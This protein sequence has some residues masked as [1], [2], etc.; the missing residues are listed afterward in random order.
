VVEKMA[1]P[2]FLIAERFLAVPEPTLYHARGFFYHALG[3]NVHFRGDGRT[4][5]G[6]A[7]EWMTV[8]RRLEHLP[9]CAVVDLEVTEGDLDA[10][11]VAVEARGEA[12]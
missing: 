9:S 11:Q 7:L 8:N 10:L 5:D 6:S 1:H 4:R 2:E 12:L 3:C